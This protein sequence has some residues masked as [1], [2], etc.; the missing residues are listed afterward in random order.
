MSSLGGMRGAEGIDRV[1]HKGETDWIER[2][3]PVID[4][5]LENSDLPQ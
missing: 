4:S 5:N 2:P 3:V 1:F